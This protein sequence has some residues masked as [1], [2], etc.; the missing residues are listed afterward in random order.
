MT[1]FNNASTFRVRSAL[2]LESLRRAWEGVV[3][4]HR[5]LRT[6]VVTGPDGFPQQLVHG[7]F[8]ERRKGPILRTIALPPRARREGI[9]ATLR[10]G[11]LTIAIPTDGH[12]S[13]ATEVPIDVK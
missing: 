3:S 6:S 9:E 7:D 4:R 1:A 13:E 11:V 2:Q 12:G 5:T 8:E 10:D